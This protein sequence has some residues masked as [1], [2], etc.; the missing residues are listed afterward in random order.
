MPQPNLVPVSLRSSRSTH[1][2]GVSGSTSTVTALPL[3]EKLVIEK[4]SHDEIQ[5]G[6]IEDRA[7]RKRVPGALRRRT[8]QM[9]QRTQSARQKNSNSFAALA[10]LLLGFATARARADARH[11]RRIVTALCARGDRAALREIGLQG[12]LCG[13]ARGLPRNEL[14]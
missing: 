11:R 7:M 6:C 13:K 2:S 3:T 8:E 4:T 5:N 9:T 10:F 14:Q 1:S 12:G